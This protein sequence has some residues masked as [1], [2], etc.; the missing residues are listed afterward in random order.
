MTTMWTKADRDKLNEQPF[1]RDFPTD[2]ECASLIEQAFKTFEGDVTL[3]ESAVGALFVGRILGWKALRI[4]HS[5]ATY[6]KYEKA[7]GVRFKEILPEI[8]PHSKIL[9][10]VRLIDMADG[11]W[12]TIV[13]GRVNRPESRMIGT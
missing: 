1:N 7:L 3:L 4:V 9:R 13:N 8:T 12:K 5:S 10:G 6:G 11:F 2:D